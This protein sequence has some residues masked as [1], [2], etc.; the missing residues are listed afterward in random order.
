M[1]RTPVR[2]NLEAIPAVFHNWLRGAEVFDSSSSPDANVYYLEKGT[3]YFLKSAPKGTLKTEADMTV[4]VQLDGI[5]DGVWQ[6]EVLDSDRTME[7]YT[8]TAEDG[9]LLLQMP[10]DCVILLKK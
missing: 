10:H 3:G 6:A 7:A 8:V 1:K 2:L 5:A 9:K 4:T